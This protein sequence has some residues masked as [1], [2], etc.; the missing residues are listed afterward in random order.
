MK[1]RVTRY[2]TNDKKCPICNAPYILAESKGVNRDLYDWYI[3]HSPVWYA[4]RKWALERA[5][6][7][8][9]QCGNTYNLSVHHLNYNNLGKEH[10]EDLKVL[11]KTCHER[12]HGIGEG[13]EI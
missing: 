9:E 10:P 8:C 5:G 3:N 6:Y 2:K 1:Y 12:E 7:K 4:K 11:C 13:W